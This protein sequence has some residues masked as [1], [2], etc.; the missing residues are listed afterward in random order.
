MSPRLTE[1][2]L[3]DMERRAN[4]ALGEKW[5]EDRECLGEEVVLA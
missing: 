5:A 4:A 1:K 3:S 2:A